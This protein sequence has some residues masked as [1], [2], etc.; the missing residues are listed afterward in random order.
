M[1]W[2][3]TKEHTEMNVDRLTDSP[4]VYCLRSC[5]R[6]YEMILFLDNNWWHLIHK[7]IQLN[8]LLNQVKWK[9]FLAMLHY[10]LLLLADVVCNTG[11][12]ITDQQCMV[13]SLLISTKGHFVTFMWVNNNIENWLQGPPYNFFFLENAL[14]TKLLNILLKFLFLFESTILPFGDGK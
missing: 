13:F 2:K 1:K 10:H 7:I 4:V 9:F 14:K 6:C 11:A 5:I 8:Q 3:Q 12:L